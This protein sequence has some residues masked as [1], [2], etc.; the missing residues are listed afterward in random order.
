MN[1][2][3]FDY[4]CMNELYNIEGQ[5]AFF[6]ADEKVDFP[7]QSVEVNAIWRAI[8][9]AVKDRYKWAIFSD[10]DGTGYLYGLTS[11]HMSSKVM[12]NWLWA[13]FEHVDNAYRR[14]PHDEGWLIPSSDSTACSQA[15][16]DCNE[17]PTWLMGIGG[18]A[19]ENYRLR[20]TQIDYTDSY[21]VPILL[22]N[23]E[24][25]TSFQRTTSCITCHGR[26]TIASPVNE[27]AEFEF[28][29]GLADHPLSSPDVVRLSVFDVTEDGREVGHVGAPDP[30]WYALPST[31]V[32]SRDRMLQLDFVWS[33][34]K[35]QSRITDTSDDND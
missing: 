12:P 5:L 28:G 21:G 1:Q 18:T 4:I 15:P 27:A 31:G 8:T 30:A 24:L 20:G 6:Y 14:G 35:A 34:T 16:Y 2:A 22:A 17:A 26:A 19:F 25:E 29:A 33:L 9:E 3:T 23:S 11:L 7:V 10:D 32:N 13:T